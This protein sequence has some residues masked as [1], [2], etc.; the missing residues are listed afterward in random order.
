MRAD[1][2]EIP[3]SAVPIAVLNEIGGVRRKVGDAL[4]DASYLNLAVPK[5]YPLE[6]LRGGRR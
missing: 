6:G 2:R 4:E 5:P 3:P 1:M